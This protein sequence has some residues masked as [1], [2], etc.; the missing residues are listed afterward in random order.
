V[1]NYLNH[2]KIE[3]KEE[4]F[5]PTTHLQI[6]LRSLRNLTNSFEKLGEAEK[7]EEIK[8]LIAILSD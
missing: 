8:E 4:Y 6:I 5:E 7:V 1:S 3:P 2:L